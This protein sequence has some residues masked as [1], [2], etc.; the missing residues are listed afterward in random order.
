MS[1]SG[2]TPCP[3]HSGERYKR[4][5]RPLHQGK[6]APDPERLMRSRY[7]AY[8][9]GEVVYIQETTDPTGPQYQ[10]DLV[11]WADELR[12]WCAATQFLGLKIVDRVVQGDTAWVQFHATLRSNGRDASFGE[13]SAFTLLNGRWRYHSGTPR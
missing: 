5:C 11:A 9:L 7:A 13:R 2:N 1:V 4:C 10:R 12:E 6:S 3:C 8:A